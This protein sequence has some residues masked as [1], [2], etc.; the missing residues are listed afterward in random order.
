MIIYLEKINGYIS[1]IEEWFLVSAT[2]FMIVLA[3]LQVLLRNLLDQGILWADPLLR[4]LVLWLGFIGASLATKDGKHISIDVF[5]RLLKGKWKE[6][7]AII[8]NVFACFITLYLAEA[9][10]RFV[11]EEK[12]F[13]TTVFG[14]TPAWFF[15]IIIPIGFGLIAL[16][17]LIRIILSVSVLFKSGGPNQ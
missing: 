17:F 1:K 16:R 12:E 3:F 15:Q 2:I 14:E 7:S 5:G 4:H 13:G 6:I 10:W 11:M 9:A 8:I